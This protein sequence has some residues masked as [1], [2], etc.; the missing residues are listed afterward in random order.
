MPKLL[1]RLVKDRA[2]LGVEI[3]ALIESFVRNVDAAGN[4]WEKRYAEK[5]GIV[6]AAAIL[7]V[8]YDIAPFTEER[9]TAAVTNLYNVSRSLTV[10]IPQATDALLDIL[11]NA[12]KKRFPSLQKGEILKDDRR[13]AAWGV[14]RD[15][16]G[17]KDVMVVRA[18]RFKKLVQPSAVSEQVLEELAARSLLLKDPDGNKKRQL[19]IKGLTKKRVRYVCVKGLVAKLS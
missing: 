19:S 15:L 6:L 3:Q 11:R 12:Q 17:K 10:S 18:S 5:F 8:R 9:A 4:T 14:R 1:R 7:L 13:K 2:A 16:G